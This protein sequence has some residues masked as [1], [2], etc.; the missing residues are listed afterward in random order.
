MILIDWMYRK[1]T[2]QDNNTRFNVAIQHNARIVVKR[3]ALQA[4]RSWKVG[5]IR[6]T[7]RKNTL[8]S[9]IRVSL[10][11]VTRARLEL[12]AVRDLMIKSKRS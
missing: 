2:A 5:E 9:V 3:L 10:S 12:T 1:T 4:D 11:F 7:Q 8:L 6:S